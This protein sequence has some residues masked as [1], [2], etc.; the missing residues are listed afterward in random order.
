MVWSDLYVAESQISGLGGISIAIPALHQ[1]N[2]PA[3]VPLWK[4]FEYFR[5]YCGAGTLWYCGAVMLWCC[6][7]VVIFHCLDGTTGSY[8]RVRI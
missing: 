2:R 3:A 4:N 5:T 1:Q 8:R 7:A 6:G